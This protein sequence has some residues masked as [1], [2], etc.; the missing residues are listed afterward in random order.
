[1]TCSQTEIFYIYVLILR[2]LV[3]VTTVRLLSLVVEELW[4]VDICLFIVLTALD[5]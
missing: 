5:F 1:M 2:S 3:I 4:L